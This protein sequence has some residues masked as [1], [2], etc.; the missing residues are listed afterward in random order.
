VGFEHVMERLDGPGRK[1]IMAR[2]FAGLWLAA[3]MRRE[4]T[5]W[6]KLT[7]RQ[8]AGFKWTPPE[9][10]HFTLKFF[11]DIPAREIDRLTRT[12]REVTQGRKM[13]R[14][15]LGS[16]GTFPDR[17]CARIVWIGVSQGEAEL[18]ALAEAVETCSVKAGFAASRQR[19]QP[20]LT[21][22]RA[23]ADKEPVLVLSPDTI[24]DSQTEIGSFSLIESTLRSSGPLY[25]SIADFIYC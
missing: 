20:H 12:L 1:L 6:I 18:R 2:L 7:G 25:R 13:F 11:G 5:E 10:L 21:V 15:K 3:A 22:A 16:A 19:F 8:S 14:I 9:N 17:S 4:V 24:F 23:I